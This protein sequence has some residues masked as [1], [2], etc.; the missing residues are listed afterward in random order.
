M[1]KIL[2][3]LLCSMYLG[4]ALAAHPDLTNTATFENTCA[5]AASRAPASWVN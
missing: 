5:T 4:P 2:A 1:R 3:T